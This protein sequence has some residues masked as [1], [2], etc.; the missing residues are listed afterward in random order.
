MTRTKIYFEVAN[1]NQNIGRLKERRTELE[2]KIEKFRNDVATCTKRL[3][4]ISALVETADNARRQLDLSRKIRLVIQNYVDRL[5]QRKASTLQENTEEMIHKLIRKEDLVSRLE[6]NP[7]D[8]SVTLYGREGAKLKKG[9]LSAGEKEIYAICLLWGLAKT[10]GRE[11]PIIIDTP[12]SRLDSDHRRAIVEKYY[13][14]AG[15]QVIILSTDT[16]VDKQYYQLLFPSVEKS[17]LLD[18]DPIQGKTKVIT[19]YFWNPQ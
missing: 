15:S 13:P 14:A 7:K 18:Y 2:D 11:L 8:F 19:G 16:E 4:E 12:L 5:T 6:I 9:D 1:V 10:S 17:F 3:T